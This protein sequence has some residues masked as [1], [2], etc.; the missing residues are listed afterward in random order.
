[1]KSR[2]PQWIGSLGTGGRVRLNQ[3]RLVSTAAGLRKSA[4]D[5]ASFYHILFM[6]DYTYSSCLGVSS[7]A[8]LFFS[9]CQIVRH[10]KESVQNRLHSIVFEVSTG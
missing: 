9:F 7:K 1:M 8:G 10:R 2:D 4:P 5:P 3:R 6:T